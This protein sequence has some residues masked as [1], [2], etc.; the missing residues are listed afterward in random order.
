MIERTFGALSVSSRHTS[1]PLPSGSRTSSTAT[2]GPVAAMR[3]P[4]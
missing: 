4:A 3:P 2:S 1:M